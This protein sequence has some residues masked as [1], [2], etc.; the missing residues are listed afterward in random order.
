MRPGM[1]FRGTVETG[2]VEDA[3]LIPVDALFVDASGPVA[4]RRSGDGFE[5]VKL[6]LGQR[7]K[8]YVEIISGLSVGDV[9]SRSDLGGG[10]S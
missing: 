3:L 1:R 9:V 7:N 6:E 10:E 2:R 5:T 8:E 4:Y